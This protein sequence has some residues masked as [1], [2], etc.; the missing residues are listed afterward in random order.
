MKLYQNQVYSCEFEFEGLDI[1]VD[2]SKH[3]KYRGHQRGFKPAY[4]YAAIRNAI[5]EILDLKDGDEFVLIDRFVGIT[6]VAGLHMN[7]SSM[8]T[9]DIITLVDGIIE[10]PYYT[11]KKIDVDSGLVA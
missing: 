5:D 6:I 4:F 9:I 2:L 3:A 11:Q 8:L 1:F 7:G 10:T